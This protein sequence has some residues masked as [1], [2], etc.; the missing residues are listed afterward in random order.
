[1]NTHQLFW[2]LNSE[3]NVLLIQF[4]LPH[5]LKISWSPLSSFGSPTCSHAKE[6]S[7][8]STSELL[9]GWR[10]SMIKFNVSIINPV[11]IVINPTHG[12]SLAYN[13]C[14]P[15]FDYSYSP[16]PTI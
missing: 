13:Q 14:T 8:A 10:I 6:G 3:S 7:T 1:M 15:M 4:T 2:N 11:F 16:L 5:H 12:D 9:V